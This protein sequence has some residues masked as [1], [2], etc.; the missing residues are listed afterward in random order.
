[1]SNY[2]ETSVVKTFDLALKEKY[3]TN[4]TKH[5]KKIKGQRETKIQNEWK[6]N[7]NI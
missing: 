7:K 2:S 4:E 6:I 5:R 3:R 1:M